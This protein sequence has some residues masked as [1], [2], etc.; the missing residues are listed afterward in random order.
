[1]IR[2]ERLELRL[3]DAADAEAIGRFYRVNRDHLAPW[4]P[5]WPE[6]YDTADYWA[7]QAARAAGELETNRRFYAFEPGGREVIGS[8]ALTGIMRGALRQCYLGYNLAAA[9]QGRGLGREMAAAAVRH[10]FDELGMHRVVASH[11]PAN[12]RSAR[13]LRALGFE[14]EGLAR[15]YL[16]IAGRWEDHVVTALINPRIDP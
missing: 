6:G 12:E 2:T 11:M 5:R 4:S 10:A 3:L 8:V 7:L 14:A 15:E 13:L 16:A 9:A 1:M